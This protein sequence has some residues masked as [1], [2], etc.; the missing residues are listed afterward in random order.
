MRAS[1]ARLATFDSIRLTSVTPDLPAHSYP[2]TLLPPNGET[3]MLSRNWLVC[4]LAAALVCGGLDAAL[5]QQTAEVLPM[6]KVIAP[7]APC[8]GDSCTKAGVA[9]QPLAN[10]KEREI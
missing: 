6:P 9:G 3:V 8:C 10:A 5:A 2:A 7:A 1:E 4:F